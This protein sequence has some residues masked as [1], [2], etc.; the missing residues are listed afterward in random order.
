MK[1]IS[2]FLVIL[3]SIVFQQ[4][5][6]LSGISLDPNTET[7]YVANF[8]N[9]AFSSPAALE[10]TV[11]EALNNKIRTETRLIWD[12]TD[13]DV[14]FQGSLVD[15]VVTSEAPRAG[16]TTAINRLTI[17]LAVDYIVYNEDGTPNE[18][19]GWKSN[20]SFFYD[21]DAGIDL[22]SI[23]EEAIDAILEQ[24]MQ[25]IFQKAFADW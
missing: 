19:K 5:Y 9:N 17:R 8:K 16:E 11:Q 18:D 12:D 14:E 20:F 6:S 7:Y 2:L 15:Y 21:F 3:T 13:P 22:S 25:D 1:R 4:C 10:V 24:L 23:E